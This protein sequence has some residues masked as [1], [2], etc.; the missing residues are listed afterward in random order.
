MQCRRVSMRDP[1]QPAS[2]RAHPPL[3][4]LQLR[5]R[6]LALPCQL[7]QLLHGIHGRWWL[8]LRLL[9]RRLLFC[10]GPLLALLLLPAH[11]AARRVPG[12]GEQQ[13]GA[14]CTRPGTKAHQGNA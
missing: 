11:A 2:G 13:R 5:V 1:A 12:D 3:H 4:F 8:L 6:V 7:L 14:L 9:L 10:R